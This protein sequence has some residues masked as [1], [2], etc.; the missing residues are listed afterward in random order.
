MMAR[1]RLMADVRRLACGLAMA[2]ALPG[3]VTAQSRLSTGASANYQVPVMSWTDIPFRTV[4]RQ[5]Y[6]F[7][8]GSAAVATLLNYHYDHPTSEVP[9]FQAMWAA[10][11]QPVIRRLGFSMLDIK[12]YLDGIGFRTEGFRLS[13]AQLGN[14]RRP[15]IIILDLRGYRHFVVVKGVERGQILVGDPMLGITRYTIADLTAHWNGIFLAIVDAPRHD[16]P[17]FNVA[18]EWLPWSTAPLGERDLGMPIATLTDNLP[19]LYQI[20]P[21]VR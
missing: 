6:D 13:P 11:D 4:I 14:V 10:G 16:R 21:S 19:P 8:C 9:I 15:G 18:G 5:R 20:T 12:R 7:S 1:G 17:R 3:A 2:A